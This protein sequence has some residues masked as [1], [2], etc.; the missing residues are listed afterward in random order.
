MLGGV[1]LLGFWGYLDAPEQMLSSEPYVYN[2]GSLQVS[3]WNILSSLVLIFLLQ[4]MAAILVRAIGYAFSSLSVEN[5]TALALLNKLINVVIY[6]IFTLIAI[7][8]LGLDIDT[9]LVLFGGLGVG[10]GI[11]LQRITSNFFSGILLLAESRNR[12]GDLIELPGVYG[13]VRKIALRYTLVETFDGR[14]VLVPNEELVTNQVMNWTLSHTRGRVEVEFGVAYGS[15]LRK[16]MEIAIAA[17]KDHSC[18]AKGMQPL[19]FLREFADS[20]INFL[21]IFHVE[22]VRDGRY[23]PQSDVMLK[24]YDEFALAG[25]QIPFPQRDVHLVKPESDKD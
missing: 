18:T 1:A 19:C 11:G 17:A 9:L 8:I 2:L 25:I 21:L 7:D 4:W 20:S 15:D 24:I 16:A 6:T 22:D 23:G 10:I 13:F 14:E 5:R 12:I 3:V